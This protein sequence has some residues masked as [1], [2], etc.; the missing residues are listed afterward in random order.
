[1]KSP[2][3]V[4]MP[5]TH[6]ILFACAEPQRGSVIPAQGCAGQR[7][8]GATLGKTS[9]ENSN[10]ERVASSTC[11]PDKFIFIGG[12]YGDDYYVQ[13]TSP[14]EDQWKAW[15]CGELVI[16]RIDGDRNAYDPHGKDEWHLIKEAR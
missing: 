4:L 10:P 9:E 12:A 11:V 8:P 3:A 6:H 1:M 13:N 14:N 7:S 2:I 16:I 15:S 5:I